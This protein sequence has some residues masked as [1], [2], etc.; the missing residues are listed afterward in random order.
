MQEK[1]RKRLASLEA[2]RTVPNNNESIKA[3]LRIWAAISANAEYLDLRWRALLPSTPAGEAKQC[4]YRA[5][6]LEISIARA[7]GE[8]RLA[9]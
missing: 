3:I 6:Q 7:N 8:H 5:R 9:E 1:S 4:D 2:I